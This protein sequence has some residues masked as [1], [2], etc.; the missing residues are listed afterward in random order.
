MFFFSAPPNKEPKRLDHCERKD[1]CGS[2][3]LPHAACSHHPSPLNPL[4]LEIFLGVWE[5]SSHAQGTPGIAY[6]IFIS[7]AWHCLFLVLLHVLILEDENIFTCWDRLQDKK[8]K[9]Y[10]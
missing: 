8:W 9:Q 3:K 1:F 7:N 6:I 10:F 4:L 2:D 5:G